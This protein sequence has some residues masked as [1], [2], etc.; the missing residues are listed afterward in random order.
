MANTFKYTAGGPVIDNK[1][2]VPFSSIGQDGSGQ[3]SQ[4]TR[5]FLSPNHVRI[6]D[7]NSNTRQSH[8]IK[9]LT[10]GKEYTVSVE[11]LKITGA[12]TFR[13]QIQ[14][15]TDNTYRRTIKFTNT[16][17]TGLRDIDGWQTATWTFS[18]AANENAV[19]IWW[20]DGADYTTY[21]HSFELRYPALRE[22]H[23]GTSSHVGNWSIG[24]NGAGMGPT[25]TGGF[26]KGAEIPE[27]GYAIYSEGPRVR[28]VVNDEELMTVLNKMGASLP[29]DSLGD[30]LQWAKDNNILV[31]DKP[32]T[33]TKKDSVVLELDTRY[34][35][36][37]FQQVPVTNM[38]SAG[39]PDLNNMVTW[40]NSGSW[41]A[42]GNATDI[43]PPFVNGAN[44]ALIMRGQ[45][46]TT[47]SQHFGC[48]SFA[49]IGGQTYTMSVWYRQN[50]AGVSSPY[51]RTNI[52]NNS[53][54]NLSYN[55]DTNSA[56]WPVNEWIRISKTAT[57]Q[58]NEGGAYLSNYLGRQ[59]GDTAWY[60]APM[61]EL[62]STMSPFVNGTRTQNSTLIDLSG[63]SNN[64][65]INGEVA[66]DST[67]AI[68]F[69]GA[70]NYV[71]V[72]SHPSFNVDERTIEITFKMN[73]SYPSFAPLAVYA[74]GSSSTYRLWLGLQSGKFQMHGWGTTDPT[75][76]TSIS[77]GEWYTCAFS[78]SNSTKEMKMYTNGKL[79]RTMQNTQ[80]GIPA[81]SG[82]NWYLAHMPGGESWQGITHSDVTIQSFRVHDRILSDDEVAQNY[83]EGPIATDGLATAFDPSNLVS[84]INGSTTTNSLTGSFS[85][86]LM[87]GVK[88]SSINCG[89]WEFDGNDDYISIPTYTFGNGNWALNMWVNINNFSKAYFMS[90]SS[91]GPVTNVFDA[92]GGQINYRNYD[93]TWK[94]HPGNTAL[95]TG[96]WYMLTWV[97]Y[98]GSTNQDGTMKMYVNGATDSSVF[99]SFTTNGG[100]CN[101]I[102]GY[103]GPTRFDGRIGNISIYTRS[104]SDSE[105]LQNYNA[106]VTRFK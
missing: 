97:N 19:R 51:F 2:T 74:N 78:Y 24:V 62:G 63:K 92:Y 1:V 102:G 72:D 3:G 104:L 61:V 66:F 35:A 9:N 43:E 11:Y 30:G 21:T 31:V 87:N 85:G 15:Y 46:N 81:Q 38:L 48:A 101:I 96:K 52:N 7:T 79:E 28:T 77:V 75:A 70:T 100:P 82:M 6:V 103:Y 10:P 71:Q 84:Y 93:G 55:G 26:R 40:T 5:T 17:E 95:S 57:L 12:P 73:S 47:G 83:Y 27:G 80:G 90:N 88:Y 32:L 91:G 64:G 105:V 53:L 98:A 8:L 68:S 22:S 37:Y 39:D 42:N 89:V 41:V 50:R 94:N 59:K 14:G 18:L 36:G 69:D 34:A 29:V 60:Y 25:S 33:S 45:S 65:T 20:Q 4:G 76:T 56:N 44:G 13:F 58:A 99:N 49:G 54:G 106:H 23:M 86:S 67:G 16:E